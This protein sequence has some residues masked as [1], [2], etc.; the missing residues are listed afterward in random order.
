MSQ[1][2]K[3]AK[4]KNNPYTKR[5]FTLPFAMK[6]NAI[7][8]LT[9]PISLLRWSLVI[10]AMSLLQYRQFD[11]QFVVG[12]LWVAFA[13]TEVILYGLITV[14]FALFIMA[15]TYKIRFFGRWKRKKSPTG[16]IWWI[17]GVLTVGCPACSIT[18]ASFIGLSSL[19]ILLP[20]KWLEVKF[21][22][23]AL[24]AYASYI[25]IRD[26]TVCKK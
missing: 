10:F 21:I 12:N 6:Q 1:W 23:V 15:Q 20:F 2:V 22:A 19:I 18:I 4:E 17:V 3:L 5:V 13:W 7:T 8:I 26:L 24:L 9:D 16:I 14:L 25:T 11:F